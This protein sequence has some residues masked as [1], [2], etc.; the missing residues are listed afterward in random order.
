ME[1]HWKFGLLVTTINLGSLL[2]QLLA[3]LKEVIFLKKEF[4]LTEG[5]FNLSNFFKLQ[6]EHL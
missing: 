2:T 5:Y 4:H 3:A 6:L 1:I